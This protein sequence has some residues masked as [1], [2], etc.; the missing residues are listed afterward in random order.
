[1]Q[2]IPLNN[3]D[4]IVLAIIIAIVTLIV[5]GMLHGSIRTC[6]SPSCA[7]DCGSCGSRCG[8]PHIKLSRRQRAQ[9]R[10]IDRRA[11]EIA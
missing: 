9:L 10:E 5:R 6:D 7:G 3:A 1:M 4:A 11:K 2:P 8:A